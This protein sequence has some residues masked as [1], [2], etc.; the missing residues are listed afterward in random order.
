MPFSRAI[1]WRASKNSK[2]SFLLM[3]PAVRSCTCC[4]L[5][6]SLLRSGLR[7]GRL[8]RRPPLE[9]GAG[10]LDV[11]V[12]QRPSP[13]GEALVVG[14]VQAAGDPPLAVDMGLG[15]DRHR[16]ADVAMEVLGRA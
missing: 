13:H 11:V 6:V 12:A 7:S 3:L 10:P 9:D 4:L 8:G 5:L 16:R 2:L 15:L 14:V 1:I